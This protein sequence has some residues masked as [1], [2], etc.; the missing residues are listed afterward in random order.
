MGRPL[1]EGGGRQGK[2]RELRQG[3]GEELFLGRCPPAA[4][5]TQERGSLR[6]YQG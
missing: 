4:G 5:Q 3:P 1:A 6:T 2:E